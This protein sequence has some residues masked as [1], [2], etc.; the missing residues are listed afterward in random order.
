M[1]LCRFVQDQRHEVGFYDEQYVTPIDEAARAM[2]QATGEAFPL[3]YGDHLLAYL[4]P[5]GP[6]AAGAAKLA[7]WLETDAA[8]DVKRLKTDSLQLLVPVP[9]PPKLFLLAGNYAAHIQEGGGI[10]AER[11]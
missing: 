4:P 9:N 10:A 2:H 3:D 7:K 8:K 1:R 6:A 11:A 5:E